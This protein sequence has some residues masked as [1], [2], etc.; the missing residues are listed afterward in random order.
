[1][2]KDQTQYSGRKKS[3][4]QKELAE[5]NIHMQSKRV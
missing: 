1:M 2:T 3:L 4:Q 5:L